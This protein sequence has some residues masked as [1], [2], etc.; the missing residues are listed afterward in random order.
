MIVY[1]PHQPY[2]YNMSIK[3]NIRLANESATDQEIYQA[4]KLANAHEFIERLENG[5]DTVMQNSGS[6]LSGG[7]RRRIAI[8]RAI[9]KNAPVILMDE[10]TSALDNESEQMIADAI[11]QLRNQ[12]TVIMIAHRTATIQLVDNVVVC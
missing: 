2:L 1:V 10:A 3:D 12:K 4:A 5:Y 6:N 11:S 8:A 9:L 7:Q